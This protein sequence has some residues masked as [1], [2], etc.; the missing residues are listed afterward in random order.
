MCRLNHHRTAMKLLFVHD[1]FGAW[2]GAE[3][4]L[5]EVAAALRRRGHELA[6]LH[7]ASTGKSEG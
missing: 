3:S 2:A 6:L 1:R 5:F 4:N 7:G